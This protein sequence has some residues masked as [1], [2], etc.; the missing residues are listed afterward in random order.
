MS[1][2]AADGAQLIGRNLSAVIAGT[3]VFEDISIELSPGDRVGLVGP[4]GAGKST[5][6]RVLAGWIEPRAGSLSRMPDSAITVLLDQER[7]SS[8]GETVVEYLARRVGVAD[9]ERSLAEATHAIA[10]P[11]AASASDV[12]D[13]YDRALQRWLR[14]GVADFEARAAEVLDDLGF[15]DSWLG[16]PVAD[17]SGGERARV[18]LAAVQ[19]LTSDVILLDE[20]TNDLDT[21]GLARLEALMMADRRPRL[22]VSH[23]RRFLESV[24]NVVVD[25]DPHERRLTRFNG[26]WSSY[27]EARDVAARQA[28]EAYEG[29][30]RARGELLDQARKQREWATKGVS[31]AKKSDESDKLIRSFNIETSEKLAGKA[32]RA[33]RALERLEVVDKP[34]EPWR[35]QFEIGESGRSGDMVASLTGAVIQRGD[36]TSAFRMGPIDLELSAGERVRIAGPNGAGK[37]T[38]VQSLLGRAPLASGEQRLG[39]SVEI[40]ELDQ[41]RLRIDAA[42]PVLDALIDETSLPL[43]DARAL[44]ATFGLGADHVGRTLATLSPGERTRL[45]L[46]IF[47]GR[48]VN[49]LVLD[50]PTN[51]LD[52]AAVEQLESALGRFRGAVILITHD[53]AFA[54]AIAIDRTIDLADGGRLLSDTVRMQ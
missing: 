41:E 16:K 49:T 17:C 45:L 53:R 54:E 37:T 38:L 26:S 42:T 9:A 44:L 19:L 7:E 31:R 52:L 10:D 1:S 33:E 2:S 39:S 29:Y 51:H 4:N 18:G 43:S 22:V 20:P 24:V 30:Q 14:L 48:G 6:L 34:W 3:T 15:P 11:A 8:E 36:G 23:D 21:A 40:G 12:A 28:A 35:L 50:E 27:L 32:A 47:Q 25:M 5:L 13:A 46:A